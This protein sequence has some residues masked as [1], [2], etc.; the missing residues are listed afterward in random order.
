MIFQSFRDLVEHIIAEGLDLATFATT[1]WMVWYR[2]NALRTTNKL[3]PIQ[4]V[5]PEVR[6]V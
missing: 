4:Q 1:V 5:L 2:R 6:P 3:F